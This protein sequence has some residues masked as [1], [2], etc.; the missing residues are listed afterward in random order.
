MTQKSMN[1]STKTLKTP[2]EKAPEISCAHLF[3]IFFRMGLTTFGGGFSMAT[4]LRHEMVL[5][6]QWLSERDFLDTLAVASSVPGAV[7]VNLAFLEGSRLR[8]LPG[9]MAAAAGQ[10][11]PSIL[12]ILV[13]AKFAAS[14]FEEPRVAAF[15]K[16]AAIAVAGQIAFAA[17]SFAVNFG[18]T[19]R[20]FLCAPWGF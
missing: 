18:S 17:L 6:R 12:V 11:C 3:L 19:G 5:K 8:G 10:I 7:A 15:L 16:G 1:L 14:Y 9:G 4:V 13:I 2:E 20:I